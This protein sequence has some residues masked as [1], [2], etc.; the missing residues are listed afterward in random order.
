M[1]H[2]RHLILGIALASALLSSTSVWAEGGGQCLHHDGGRHVLAGHRGHGFIGAS[3]HLY[4]HLLNNKQQLGL[5]E[6]QILTLRN[7]ALD[8]DRAVIRADADVRISERE[9]RALLRDHKTDL[10]TIETKVREQEALKG[11]VR[12]IEIKAR[13]EVIALLTPDQKTKLKTLWEEHRHQRQ[14][15]MTRAGADGAMPGTGMDHG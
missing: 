5:T 4:R 1:R 13:R 12:M 6:E 8:T 7:L 11:T 2:G 10:S 14:G 9:L 3:A 15:P